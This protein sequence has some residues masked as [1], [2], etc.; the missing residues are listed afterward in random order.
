M[1]LLI[2]SSYRNCRVGLGAL[3]EAGRVDHIIHLGDEIERPPDPG[4]N[5]RLYQGPRQL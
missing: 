1:K 4:D 5:G 3:E 2:L